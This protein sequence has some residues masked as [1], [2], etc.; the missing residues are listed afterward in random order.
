V[1]KEGEQGHRRLKQRK[2]YGA[3]TEVQGLEGI[4]LGLGDGKTTVHRI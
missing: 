1:I 2:A 4:V 3:N